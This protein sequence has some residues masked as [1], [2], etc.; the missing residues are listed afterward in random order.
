MRRTKGV[1]EA[2]LSYLDNTSPELEG[3]PGVYRYWL[4]NVRLPV[5]RAI[6]G[7]IVCLKKTGRSNTASASR[8]QATKKRKKSLV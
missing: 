8:R 3:E 6:D 7:A 2:T 5:H 1:L 4:E